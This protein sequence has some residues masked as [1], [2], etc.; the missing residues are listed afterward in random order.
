MKLTPSIFV[1]ALLALA[2]LA[3]ASYL[4]FTGWNHA[5]ITNG[6]QTFT[7]ICGDLDV[8]VTGSGVNEVFSTSDVDLNIRSG[9]NTGSAS[10][11]FTFSEPVDVTYELMS[12]DPNESISFSASSTPVYTHVEGLAPTE[13][14]NL[15][16]VGNAFGLA[17]DGAARGF[18]DMANVSS[19]TWDYSS[20]VINKFE[21]FRIDKTIVPEPN[22]FVMIALGGLALLLRRRRTA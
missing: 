22:A 18:V 5:Q 21:W 17:P 12:L 20:L 11:T 13:S 7:D 9:A 8:T 15:T 3:S 1:V 16:L 2:N 14:G 10:F 19:F 4:D 6:G